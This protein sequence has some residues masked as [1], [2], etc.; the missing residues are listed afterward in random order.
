[1]REIEFDEIVGHGCVAFNFKCRQCG[2]KI[3]GNLAIPRANAGESMASR[4]ETDT[5][6]YKCSCGKVYD[7]FVN[8]TDLFS[9]T[10]RIEGLDDNAH[11]KCSLIK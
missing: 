11:V 7:V 3:E 4:D 9:A 5:K 2:K 10:L 8:A 6:H 1:M